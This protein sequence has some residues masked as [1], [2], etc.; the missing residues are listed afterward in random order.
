LDVDETLSPELLE[1]A[2]C[3][4]TVLSSF[5]QAHTASEQ[6]LEHVLGIKRLERLTERIGEERVAQRDAE[7]AAFEALPLLEKLAA[8]AGVKSPE[9]AA[10][11]PDGGRL[12]L[13]ERNEDAHSHWYEYK[14]GC[15]KDMSSP[16]CET[17]PCPDVPPMFLERDRIDR[18]TR[19]IGKKA[20]DTQAD[21]PLP[22][23]SPAGPPTADPL[24]PPI[25]DGPS[26]EAP[27]INSSDVIA[28]RRDCR[29]FGRML[30][31]RAWSLGM[32]ASARKAFV[33]DGSAWIHGIWERHF[34]AFG[35]VQILDIIHALTYVFA[36]A[37][38]GRP[39]D[40]GWAIYVRWITWVWQGQVTRVIGELAARQQE[41]GPPPESDGPTSVRRIV[42]EALT[43]LQ[44][45]RT[46][47]NYPE[48]RQ[49]GL[50]ITS[51]H[52]ESTVK[53]L[54]HRVK[55]TEKFWS[56]RGAEALL[57]L[58]ADTLSDTGHWDHFW[59]SRPHTMTGTRH[60]ARSKS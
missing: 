7:T 55:G 39:P 31:A 36:A 32:L 13:C 54:N 19:E 22:D 35:F 4:G 56:E 12:Q 41:L 9:M 5:P 44:N 16:T 2:A 58:K 52:I 42:S 3:L 6:L 15:L 30:L 28:T 23:V 34:R 51:S 37:T 57:Q 47:M 21:P 27:Q 1:K 48:Y 8:P 45:H 40:E 17:D 49:Q 38:A 33:G 29:A 14:A 43:Y 53:L 25:E 50:P 24:P 20:A 10:V 60:Y 59:Q 26:Y 18:L 46:Q 11:M